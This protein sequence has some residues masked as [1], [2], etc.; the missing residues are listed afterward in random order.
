M[1]NTLSK[2]LS[3]Y[4]SDEIGK[5]LRLSKKNKQK[6]NNE[7]SESIINQGK[8]I[9]EFI[10]I[11]GN[12][13]SQCREFI[14]D[15][16]SGANFERTGWN[17]LIDE[18]E[19]GKIK[20]VITKNLSRLGRSNFECEYYMNYYFNEKNVRFIT[21]QEKIDTGNEN[22]TINEY[23]AVN[24]FINEKFLRDLS[25]N[26]KNSNRIKQE[27]GKY[28]GN[29]ITP[30]G[31]VK[32]PKDKNSLI[33]DDYAAEVVKKIYD[34]YLETKSIKAV[35]KKL[36]ENKILTPSHY[37]SSIVGLKKKSSNPFLWD[38]SVVKRILTSQM[39]IGN[40]EQHKFEKRTFKEK[41]LKR[42]PKEE[43]IIVKGTHKAIIDKSIY[44]KV[45]KVI[46]NNAKNNTKKRKTELLE[47]L[48]VCYDCKHKMS[49]NFKKTILKNGDSKLHIYTAC[50]HYRKNRL[51]N[52]C[53][54]HSVNYFT[55]EKIVLD[56][57]ED[58]CKKYIK[59]INYKK[60]TKKKL[61]CMNTYEDMLKSNISK[62][63]NEV[64][65]IDKKLETMYID[66]LEDIISV[67]T[68]KLNSKKF[69]EKK[70]VIEKELSELESKY[71]EYKV[72]NSKEKKLEA[73][74]IAKKYIKSKKKIDRSFILKLIDRIE[75][76]EDGGLDI[77][78][79]IKPFE[80]IR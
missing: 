62:C 74:M 2:I 56:N 70:K 6:C 53:S 59:S 32:N 45:Q 71:N 23:A 19:K 55:I 38:S 10:N 75:V 48:L 50:N 1:E 51:L 69:E 39:Y 7:D 15:G 37:F 58:I 16:K 66:R 64:S 42:I 68:F 9:N 33:I 65:K 49:L 72:D 13:G 36:Y 8:I 35:I 31:Y 79:K 44:D 12:D 40:M 21:V 24:N 4:S 77:Y 3:I 47:N 61:N 30:Y 76:H 57:L 34:W 25:K 43:W 73:E 17:D 67:D 28:C 20:V 14:D 11:H 54:L 52:I 26:I 78:Y 18:I 46:E 22:N 41:S 29:S 63:K 80:E 60:I 27:N 5:Y